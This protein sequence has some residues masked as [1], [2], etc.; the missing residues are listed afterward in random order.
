A[1]E[2]DRLRGLLD[3]RQLAR[4][5]GDESAARRRAASS[6]D[7]AEGHYRRGCVL[8]AAGRYP[9]A[10]AG[11]LAAAGRDKKLGSSKV[12]E[13]MVEVFLIVGVRS[14]LADE[15]RDRLARVLY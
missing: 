10:L 8:A 9:E 11:L 15:Y 5:F 6:P 2:V 3:L 1:S 14:E 4:E 12:R 7:D 13:A